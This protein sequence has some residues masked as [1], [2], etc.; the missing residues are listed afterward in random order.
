MS[1]FLRSLNTLNKF[2]LPFKHLLDSLINHKFYFRGPTPLT[3]LRPLRKADEA[4]FTMEE[5]LL[6]LKIVPGDE[7][8]TWLQNTYQ[9][10]VRDVR[11][12]AS[13]M[14]QVSQ[15]SLSFLCTLLQMSE[16]NNT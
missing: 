5:I 7:L 3:F 14:G 11:R 2:P 4:G 12:V 1:V 13:N 10:L 16:Q 9:D 15:L 6:A 8:M